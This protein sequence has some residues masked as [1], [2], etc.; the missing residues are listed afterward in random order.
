MDPYLRTS[1]A[2]TRSQTHPVFVFFFQHVQKDEPR[3]LL[4]RHRLRQRCLS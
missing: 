2:S 1:A 3:I 4:M